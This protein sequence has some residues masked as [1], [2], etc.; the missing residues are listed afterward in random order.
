MKIRFS[1][2]SLK[3]L[4][5]LG[6]KKHETVRLKLKQLSI[7]VAE[8]GIIPYKELHIK[9]LVG[10]W[11]GFMRMRIGDIRVIFRIV[12]ASEE[13]FIYEMDFRGSAYQ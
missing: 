8:R 7:S 6:D 13:I 12:S 1:K 5:N 11:K 10:D 2:Q 4:E 3:F 9:N